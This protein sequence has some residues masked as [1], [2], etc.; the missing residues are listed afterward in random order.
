MSYYLN[1]LLLEE[2]VEVTALEN[3]IKIAYIFPDILTALD[4]KYIWYVIMKKD[5]SEE[6]ITSHPKEQY[7]RMRSLTYLQTWL[8][9]IIIPSRVTAFILVKKATRLTKY[10]SLT[11][12]K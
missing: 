2:L 10:G 9:K 12:K 3:A 4:D 5:Y 11:P 6:Q 7:F 8:K 1:Q